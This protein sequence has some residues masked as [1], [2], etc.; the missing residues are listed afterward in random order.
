MFSPITPTLQLVAALVAFLICAAAYPLYI[1]WL[2]AKQVEQFIREEGPQSHAAK[3][4]TPTMGGLCFIGGACLTVAGL[5]LFL[6]PEVFGIGRRVF[7]LIPL[8]VGLVCAAVGWLDDYGKVTSQSNRGLSASKRLGIELALG[9]VLGLT[10]LF[11]PDLNPQLTII[12]LAGHVSQQSLPPY[13]SP[14]TIAY[15]LLLCP[16]AVAGASNAVNLH[17]GMDGLAGGTAALIF[18]TL[19]YMCWL[20]GS[21]GY[22]AIAAAVAGALLAFLLFNRYPATVFMGDTG[23]LFLGGLLA[24][25]VYCSGLTF[26]LLPLGVLYIISVL[27][28]MAR[29]VSF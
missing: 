19:A 3:A 22:G 2:K 28:V 24:G 21:Y 6:S 7:L 20:Q 1:K 17:D 4:K 10:L 15:F 8:A 29:V 27:S 25:L 5:L 26:W 18:A 14:W 23:S 13:S 12:D 11:L 16:L 9:V